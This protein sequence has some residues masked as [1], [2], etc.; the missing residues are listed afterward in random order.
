DVSE[1]LQCLSRQDLEVEKTRTA[2]LRG[3]FM[4]RAG[5]DFAA[6]G[7]RSQNGQLRAPG[8][9]RSLGARSQGRKLAAIR[10]FFDF[11]FR[12]D[13]ITENPAAGLPT[14]RFFRALPAR[15]PAEDLDRVLNGAATQESSSRRSAA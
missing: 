5:V 9:T 15:V 7:P 6:R 8:A 1:L 2:D 13:A 3:H 12:R 11:L 14:P 4:Q 10:H